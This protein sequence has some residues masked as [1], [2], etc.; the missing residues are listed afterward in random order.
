MVEALKNIC[1][2]S[3][4]SGISVRLLLCIFLCLKILNF[5][6]LVDLHEFNLRKFQLKVQEPVVQPLSQS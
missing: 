1:G 5:E 4:V 2:L 3:I 6:G